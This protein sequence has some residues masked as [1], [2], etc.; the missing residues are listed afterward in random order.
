M[1]YSCSADKLVRV[2][3]KWIRASAVEAVAR[4]SGG[5]T[6][7]YLSSGTRI[8]VGEPYGS[9]SPNEVIDQI[10]GKESK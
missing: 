8:D 9:P 7:I 4:I 3:G 5:R 10:F 1:T 6:G 2:D